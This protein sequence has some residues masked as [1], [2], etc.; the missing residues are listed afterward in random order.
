MADGMIVSSRRLLAHLR[1]GDGDAAA[2]EIGRHLRSLFS[3][4][5]P[6]WPGHRAIAG[7]AVP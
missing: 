2:P 4:W 1:T 7:E 5:H 3:T 6:A